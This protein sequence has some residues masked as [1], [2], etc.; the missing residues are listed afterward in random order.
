MPEETFEQVKP[1]L[2]RFTIREEPPWDDPSHGYRLELIVAFLEDGE[3]GQLRLW[4]SHHEHYSRKK[5]N[6]RW[7]LDESLGGKTTYHLSRDLKTTSLSTAPLAY[8]FFRFVSGPLVNAK[9][10]EFNP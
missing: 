8:D 5:K 10:G 4:Y 7:K 3:N 6:L 1:N 9:Q 2:Y